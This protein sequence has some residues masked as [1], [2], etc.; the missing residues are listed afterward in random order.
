[1]N[2]RQIIDLQS[3]VPQGI[4]W[5]SFRFSEPSTL[6]SN[7]R[8]LPLEELL[9]RARPTGVPGLYAIMLFDS[10]CNPRPFRVIYFGQSDNIY[11]RASKTHENYEDWCKAA[12]RNSLYVSFYEMLGSTELQREI[13]ETTLIDTY[14]PICNDKRSVNLEAMV[15][16]LLG[17]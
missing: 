5:G 12:G 2:L 15:Q 9:L 11:Y 7:L 4:Q 13:D 3:G 1:M 10:T 14:K 16:T 17:K 8:R 6:L